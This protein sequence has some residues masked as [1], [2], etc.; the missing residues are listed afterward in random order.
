MNYW[1]GLTIIGI[2]TGLVTGVIGA[3]PE[4]LIVP[5]L[6]LFNILDSTKKRIG[7][8]LFMLLPPIGLFAAL[9]FYNKGFVDVY[10][11]LYMALIF[12]IAASLS[13]EYSVLI[14]HNYLRKIF[15]VF[16]ILLGIYY[17]Y[18]TDSKMKSH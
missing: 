6:A 16:T 4:V 3:G 7:T 5:L 9:K 1:L 17:F 18:K 10:A 13:S 8:S 15:A 12:T 11:A 2:L 14:N